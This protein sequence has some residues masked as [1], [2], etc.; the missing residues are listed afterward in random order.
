[1]SGHDHHTEAEAEEVDY[2]ETDDDAQDA[3][4]THRVDRARGTRRWATVSALV[5]CH[6]AAASLRK[7]DGAVMHPGGV[8]PAWVHQRSGLQ[9]PWP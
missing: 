5:M 3:E 4:G 8:G 9:Q 2:G 1:M 6:P 7:V